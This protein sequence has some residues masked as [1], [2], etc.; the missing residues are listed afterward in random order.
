MESVKGIIGNRQLSAIIC[1]LLEFGMP[2]TKLEGAADGEYIVKM[3]GVDIYNPVDNT[4][5][6][7]LP[8]ISFLLVGTIYVKNLTSGFGL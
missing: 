8:R 4:V 5:A 2:R 3:E 1:W 6:L 7:L